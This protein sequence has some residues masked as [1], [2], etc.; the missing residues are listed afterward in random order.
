MLQV[1]AGVESGPVVFVILQ[2][3]TVHYFGKEW[4]DLRS[5]LC[6]DRGDH[7]LLDDLKIVPF[8]LDV[9]SQNEVTL[10][11]TVDL[12]KHV[13]DEVLR[14]SPFSRISCWFVANSCSPRNKTPASKRVDSQATSSVPWGRGAIFF[15]RSVALEV[16]EALEKAHRG[17]AETALA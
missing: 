9:R 17:I 1:H 13:E 4:W 7:E 15:S 16:L 12:G 8:L 10:P 2:A 6:A 5:Q 14:N 3:L 11:V